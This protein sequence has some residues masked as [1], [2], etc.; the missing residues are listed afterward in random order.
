MNAHDNLC[1]GMGLEA[2]AGRAFSRVPGKEA[3]R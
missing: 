2:D 3:G 1:A